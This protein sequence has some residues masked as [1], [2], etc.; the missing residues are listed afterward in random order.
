MPAGRGDVGVGGRFYGTIIAVACHLGEDDTVSH[1]VTVGAG[2]SGD[3]RDPHVCRGTLEEVDVDMV[4]LAVLP[5]LVNDRVCGFG[6][7]VGQIGWK[8]DFNPEFLGEFFTS[9]REVGL[10]VGARDEDATIRKEDRLGVIQTSDDGCTKLGETLASG[11][12]WVVDEGIQIWE[13]CKPEASNALLST[14]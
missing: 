10:R 11:K 8:I 1:Q 12:G 9:I 7:S 4:S 14:I 3:K 13:V 2:G 5:I 6:P